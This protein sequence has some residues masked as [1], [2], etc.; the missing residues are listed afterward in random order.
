M[1]RLSA[2][3]DTDEGPLPSTRPSCVHSAANSGQSERTSSVPQTGALP[4]RARGC[5]QA[6][7][8]LSH[9][10]M[11]EE[12]ESPLPVLRHV[13]ERRRRDLRLHEKLH[14][15]GPRLPRGAGG[16]SGEEHLL[17]NV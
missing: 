16:A 9:V 2:N 1:S 3:V 4:C 5:R 6:S 13:L 7:V 14:P 15:V 12:E 17:R 11:A 10:K 8:I